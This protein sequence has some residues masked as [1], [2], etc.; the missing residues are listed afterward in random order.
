MGTNHYLRRVRPRE[1]HDEYHICKTSAGWV[2]HFQDSTEYQ[3]EW[4]DDGEWAPPSFH[5]VADIRNLL[6][7]GE[8]QISDEYGR[9]CEPGEESLMEFDRLCAW[10]GGK[11]FECNPPNQRYPEGDP[12]YENVMLRGTYRDPE[13]YLFTTGEFS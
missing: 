2:V 1:V 8:W 3:D 10:R 11:S 5:S 4:C 9:V 12:P 6:G 13:G 7:T